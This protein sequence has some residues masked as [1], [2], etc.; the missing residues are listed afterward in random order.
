MSP[1]HSTS[2]TVA[3]V[4]VRPESPSARVFICNRLVAAGTA[5]VPTAYDDDAD[6]V[7]Q[8]REALLEEDVM[9][10]VVAF[11]TPYSTTK[12]VRLVGGFFFVWIFCVFVC[13]FSALRQPSLLVHQRL[14]AHT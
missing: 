1:Y 9:K 5:A 4:T 14:V 11:V 2:S 8:A 12:D 3:H 13:G 7:A 6:A 10:L